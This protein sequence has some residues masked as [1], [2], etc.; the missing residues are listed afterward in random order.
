M[1]HAQAEREHKVVQSWARL[2]FLPLRFALESSDWSHCI[3]SILWHVSACFCNFL[4]V[5]SVSSSCFLKYFCMFHHFLFLNQSCEGQADNKRAQTQRKRTQF[6]LSS[7][8]TLRPGKAH[9]R[10][11]LSLSSHLYNTQ[12]HLVAPSREL[13]H[14]LIFFAHEHSFEVLWPTIN[15]FFILFPSFCA[16]AVLAWK[17][18]RDFWGAKGAV[19]KWRTLSGTGLAWLPCLWRRM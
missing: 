17:I 14:V 6:I 8:W 3:S 10:S 2:I 7:D 19:T 4:N 15:S 13:V 11:A 12:D 9:S 5:S 18:T 16:P 1:H